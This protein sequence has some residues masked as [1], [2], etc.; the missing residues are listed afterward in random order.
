[1]PKGPLMSGFEMRCLHPCHHAR[2]ILIS[3][4]TQTTNQIR[5]FAKSM[6]R[7]I[8][9]SAGKFHEQSKADCPIELEECAWPLM[10]VLK[11]IS[12]KIKAYDKLIARLGEPEFKSMVERVRTETARPR[13][14]STP[15]TDV[16]VAVMSLLARRR[17]VVCAIRAW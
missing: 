16:T 5:G 6:G 8:K 10:G 2:N 17:R 4:R 3:Q 9:C 13:A 7:R 11:T 1:M 15:P 12:L 14:R